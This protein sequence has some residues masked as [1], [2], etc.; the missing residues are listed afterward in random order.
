MKKL[1]VGLL[2]LGSFS[3][4]ADCSI[5]Y[6]GF[7]LEKSKVE[8]KINEKGYVFHKDG[9][10]HLQNAYYNAPR[11]GVINIM[12]V[13]EKGNSDRVYALKNKY[14]EISGIFEKSKRTEKRNLNKLLSCSDM[15]VKSGKSY[16]ELMISSSH[17]ARDLA[18]DIKDSQKINSKK[19]VK[20]NTGSYD[21]CEQ[22]ATST[23]LQASVN[24]VSVTFKYKDK[25]EEINSSLILKH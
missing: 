15:L 12:N 14:S 18:L 23:G 11:G 17:N 6:S 10:F 9:I 13:F 5:K 16:C 19:V 20:V 22:W 2:V 8:A 7:E 4:F 21:E 25:I 1:L 24:N 3:S